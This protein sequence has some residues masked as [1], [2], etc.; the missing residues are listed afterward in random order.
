MKLASVHHVFFQE[1][2]FFLAFSIL[3]DN[4]FLFTLLFREI[5]ETSEQEMRHVTNNAFS[6]F[7]KSNRRKNAVQAKN[8]APEAPIR[9]TKE[10][11][12][13]QKKTVLFGARI[14]VN[15]PRIFINFIF[16]DNLH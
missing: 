10:N 14:I 15:L 2:C 9:K 12:R 6:T 16:H 1:N 13:K 3:S 8:N 11:M 7:F 5:F 4:G